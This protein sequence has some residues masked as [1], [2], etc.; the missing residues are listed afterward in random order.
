MLTA[1]VVAFVLWL[2]LAVRSAAI[3]AAALFLPL[4]LVGLAW[5]ATSHW[6][7]R[8]GE[9]LAALVLSKLVIAA[10]LARSRPARQLQRGW[11]RRRGRRPAGDRRLFSL[12]PPESSCRRSRQERSATWRAQS[13]T[14]PGGPGPRPGRRQR[15]RFPGQ[16]LRCLRWRSRRDRLGAAGVSRSGRVEP[17]PPA[18]RKLTGRRGDPTARQGNSHRRRA[19]LD[20]SVAQPGSSGGRPAPGHGVDLRGRAPPRAGKLETSS[21]VL[22]ARRPGRTMSEHT[23]RYQLGPRSRRGLV[24]GWRAGQLAVVGIGLCVAT[25]VLRLL[26]AAEGA[27]V[28]LALVAACVAFCGTWPLAGRSAEQWTPVVASHL[29]RRVSAPRR[30]R[31]RSRPSSSRR[32]RAV[33]HVGGS[34]SSWTGPRAPG[35]R[36]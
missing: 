36:P 16:S 30:R 26:G 20:D 15:C 25:V 13:P 18:T 5:P 14:D 35:P 24:A 33:R 10:V 17:R 21:P 6:A 34:E 23:S 12:L 1:A 27:L 28:A 32:S 11:R 22:S 19:R 3:G 8:L 31:G 9:T 2:E 4:A 7:R 29:A